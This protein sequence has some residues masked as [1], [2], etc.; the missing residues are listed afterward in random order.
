MKKVSWVLTLSLLLILSGSVWANPMEQFGSKEQMYAQAEEL[1]QRYQSGEELQPHEMDLI[2]ATGFIPGITEDDLDEMVGP[3]DFGYMAYNHDED[4]G[5]TF[6]WIDLEDNG[7]TEITGWTSLDD[8]YAGPFTFPDGFSFSFY[9]ET[10]TQF[11]IGSNG[12][13]F[14]GGG[15]GSLGHTYIP[16]TSTPNDYIPFWQRDMHMGYTGGTRTSDAY[17]DVVTVDGEDAMVIE[18]LHIS[19][20]GSNGADNRS[21]DAQM[22]FFSDGTIVLQYQNVGSSMNAYVTI[23]IENSDGTMGTQWYYDN[24]GDLP[25]SG[26]E[27]TI[28]FAPPVADASIDGYVTDAVSGDGIEGATVAFGGSSTTT[29]ATGY[30]EFEETYSG[31][32]VA[33]VT[34]S[35]Y[36]SYSSGDPVEINT[37]D[38]TFDFELNPFP[39][40]T[41]FYDF[42]DGPGDWG[43]DPSSTTFD[44]EWGTPNTYLFSGEP[45]SGDNVWATNLD[46]GFSYGYDSFTMLST[47][48]EFEVHESG[49]LMTFW[50]FDDHYYYS[51]YDR[52]YGGFNVQ[53]SNDN[54]ASWTTV[55]IDPAYFNNSNYTN[56]EDT[57]AS[58][59]GPW[60]QFLVDLS[61]YAGES[62]KI[63]IRH[64]YDYYYSYY[65]TSWFGTAIDDITMYG[66]DPPPPASVY[67]YVLE[68]ESGDPV[69]GATVNIGAFSDVT[70]DNGTFSI[71]NIS[72]GTYDVSAESETHFPFFAEGVE[73]EPG[74]NTYLIEVDAYPPLGYEEDF[75]SG[76]GDWSLDPNSTT[77]DWEHGTPSTYMFT[78]TPHSGENVWATGL[79]GGFSYQYDAFTMLTSDRAFYIDDENAF[80]SFWA[81]DDHY[82]SGTTAYGGFNVRVSTD[83]VNWTQVDTDPAYSYYSWVTNY[84]YVHA[85]DDGPW[86]RYLAD[87]SDYYEQEVYIQFRHIYD[88]SYYYYA[89]SWFGTAID[90]ISI[91]GTPPPGAIEGVVTGGEEGTDLL[92]GCEVNVYAADGVD[93]L[94]TT[95]TDDE[96]YYLITPLNPGEYDL[97]FLAEFGHDD[98]LLED[99]EVIAGETAT[100]DITL[101]L[102]NIWGAVTGTVTNSDGDG[103]EGLTVTELLTGMTAV[104]DEDGDFFFGEDADDDDFRIGPYQFHVEGVFEGDIFYHD[105]TF[106]EDVAEGDNAFEWELADIMAPENL[107]AEWSTDSPAITLYWDDPANNIGEEMLSALRNDVEGRRTTLEELRLS[108]E[109]GVQ[110]K[111]PQLEEELALAEQTLARLER[112][113]ETGD[114]LDALSDFQGT[115]IMVD[116]LMLDV[117]VPAGMNMYTYEGLAFGQEATFQVAADYGY[118]TYVW[119]EGVT[120]RPLPPTEAGYVIEETDYTWIEICPDDGGDGTA[121]GTFG[122]DTNSGFIT[123]DN[124]DYDLYGETYTQFNVNSNGWLSPVTDNTSGYYG[125]LG[126]PSAP[127]ATIALFWDDLHTGGDGEGT[128]YRIDDEDEQFIVEYK[129][130]VLSNSSYI[131]TMQVIVDCENNEFLFSYNNSTFDWTTYSYNDIGLEDADGVEF[132]DYPQQ[133]ISD[134]VTLRLYQQAPIGEWRALTGTLTDMVTG[135]PVVGAVVTAT[136]QEIDDTFMGA[137]DENGSYLVLVDYDLGAYDLMFDAAGYISASADSVVWEGE[138][139]EAVTDAEL[140]PHGTMMGQVTNMETGD[141]LAG[142]MIMVS[143]DDLD[144]TWETWTDEDGMYYFDRMFDRNAGP[145]SMMVEMDGYVT[146]YDFNMNYGDEQFVMEHDMALEPYGSMWGLVSSGPGQFVE[147][148]GVQ[149]HDVDSDEWYTATTNEVGFYEFVTMFDRD[150]TFDMLVTKSGYEPYMEEGLAFDEG[151]YSMQADAM[152]SMVDETTPPNVAELNSNFDNGFNATTLPPGVYP[153]DLAGMGD[154]WQYDDGEN[155]GSIT[156]LNG[157]AGPDL[158]FAVPFYPEEPGFLLQADIR[159]NAEGDWAWGYP[160]YPNLVA[161]YWSIVIRVYADEDGVPG[162]LLFESQPTMNSME[163]PWNHANPFVETPEDGFWIAYYTANNDLHE[164]LYVDGVND[165]SVLA[166]TID[167]GDT[168]DE[169]TSGDPLIRALLMTESG[170]EMVMS[171]GGVQTAVEE[172]TRERASMVSTVRAPRMFGQVLDGRYVQPGLT[173]NVGDFLADELDEFY[174]FNLYYSTDGDTFMSAFEDPV[175]GWNNFVEVGS[176]YEGMDVEFYATAVND[177]MFESDPTETYTI[178]FNMA[179]GPVDTLYGSVDGATVTLNW[180]APLANADGSAL[181]DLSGYNVYRNGELLEE[182]G[183]DVETYEDEIG[184]DVSGVVIYWVTAVD[185]VPNESGVMEYFDAGLMGTPAFASGFEAEDNPI[186]GMPA[187]QDSTIWEMGAPTAGPGEAYEGENVWA[188]FL[189]TEDYLYTDYFDFLVSG[190]IAITSSGAAFTYYHW[191]DYEPDWDGY[192][193]IA[194][195]DGWE[196]YDVLEP[197][198]GYNSAAVYAFEDTPGFS[199]A[200]EGWEEVTF[201]LSDYYNEDETVMLEIGFIHGSDPYV[202][203]YFGVAVD[204]FNFYGVMPPAAGD[205]SGTVTNADDQ[206]LEGVFVYFQDNPDW[207]TYTDNFGFYEFEDVNANFAYDLGFE[208]ADYWPHVEE[209]VQPE[210][211][212]VVTVDVTLT[213]PAGEVSD[214]DLEMEVDVAFEFEGSVDFTLESTGS[215]MLEWHTYVIEGEEGDMLSGGRD[216]NFGERSVMAGPQTHNNGRMMRKATGGFADQIVNPNPAR[217][218]IA[219]NGELDEMW[220]LEATYAATDITGNHGVASAVFYEDMLVVNTVYI[221][222]IMGSNMLYWID[223]DGNLVDAYEYPEAMV[224]SDGRGVLDITH[225]PAS[226]ALIGANVDGDVFTFAPDFS[227]YE[228]VGN[229]GFGPSAIAY[230]YNAN[231]IFFRAWDAMFVMVDLDT[232]SLYDLTTDSLWQTGSATGMAYMPMDEEGYTIWTLSQN[233]EGLG[234]FLYRFNP[235]TF[236]FDMDFVTVYEAEEGRAGGMTITNGYDPAFLN[237]NTV[238]QNADGDEVHVWEGYELP[239]PWLTLDETEGMLEPEEEQTLTATFAIPEDEQA[240]YGEDT[241]TSMVYQVYF[242]GPYWVDPPVVNVNVVLTNSLAEETELPMEYALHQNYPNPF[243]PTTNIKFALIEAQEVRLSVFNVLGQE[244]MRLVDSRVEA[245][246]HVVSFDARSMAS[247]MYFYRIEAGPF[248][249][250]KKMVLVK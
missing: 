215:G 77:F 95:Y 115:R 235:E 208:H 45:Y 35:G 207:F 40:E 6:D 222:P 130:H 12:S 205:I 148:A 56:Y 106:P 60:T 121:T 139:F 74:A 236:E 179:P 58:Q 25:Q 89:S 175:T 29:D 82:I 232:D 131:Y 244:V 171:P 100:A 26:D 206:A 22:I 62:V 49:G 168:W 52:Y 32:Y 146:A 120:E 241:D 31:E 219:G 57:W 90:D 16:N 177:E 185:E 14:F 65:A 156:W 73:F 189:D 33:S 111:L 247:G 203:T 13:V 162:E 44:W 225:D 80:L 104:T 245:G 23:G 103:L 92:A 221:N 67:G 69:E 234:G 108:N 167:G 239:N 248:S 176:D 166:Y 41:A 155:M 72:S 79:T 160:G 3:D 125:S 55:D 161:E 118:D 191:F 187:F 76:P 184:D 116:D 101:D 107:M 196:T 153:G 94:A 145:Y 210:A 217:G 240:N 204:D 71:L 87:L 231:N 48:A 97:E 183:A 238:L 70:D 2:H 7:G 5:W 249:A 11:W 37:G 237:I 149:I 128:W 64:I 59:D 4:E 137:T 39:E 173:S 138:E 212:D 10:K 110:A 91:Y 202:T 214:T 141:P 224:G 68:A 193:V 119:S 85:T 250:M 163:D 194:S 19:E 46:G 50:A 165:Y 1:F 78:S 21:V 88:Y 243:N 209:G 36:F 96:G 47:S 99:V 180:T 66:L 172:P 61:D 213:Q 43:L 198:D 98:G 27:Y 126:S 197:M 158:M 182:V 223:M 218:P 188:T 20:Y 86:T 201:I 135:D 117:L 190:P 154:Y 199:G 83:G 186:F 226:G 84:E 28:L 151:V 142:A 230:D 164:P 112:A 134:G 102:I 136:N 114:E 227:E 18:V 105:D 81:W 51:Y 195:V 30:Y 132:I 220:D 152:L 144:D 17:Y 211:D 24:T 159:N 122:D 129:A 133:N 34:A 93:V 170:N 140:E 8:G 233:E 246:Y 38:N 109:P 53:V 147:G 200:T 143:N 42:E 181:V 192:R 157:T 174:G 169:S 216:F 229:I 178:E 54:G 9:G 150:H 127:N 124:L 15:S 63:R 228:L 113:L 123:L 242:N 75:E